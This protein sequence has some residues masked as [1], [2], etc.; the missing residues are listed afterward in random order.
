MAQ[1]GIL[2]LIFRILVDPQNYVLVE[3]LP[4]IKH[5]KGQLQV[6]RAHSLFSDFLDTSID[7]RLSEKDMI[8]FPTKRKLSP[9]A[10]IKLSQIVYV[11]RKQS[12]NK[13]KTV[14]IPNTSNWQLKIDGRRCQEI[15]KKKCLTF[16]FV[17]WK[18]PPI[19]FSS[20][21]IWSK[22]IEGTITGRCKMLLN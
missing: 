22:F 21:P 4:S 14:I 7:Y 9:S 12:W 15:W 8:F 6:S 2:R 10:K 16:R 1:N 13:L 11:T 19:I 18:H 3:N 5:C 17:V 20:F